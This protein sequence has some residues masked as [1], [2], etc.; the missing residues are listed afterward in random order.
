MSDRPSC[1]RR[2]FLGRAPAAAMLGAVAAAAVACSKDAPHASVTTPAPRRR[3]V[4]ENSRQGDRH[5][6]ITRPGA[7]DAIMGYAGQASVL[8]GE[9]V[10]LYV[11]TTSRAF[12]VIAFRRGWY[13]GDLARRV[14][15]SGKVRGHRQRKPTMLRATNTVQ[16]D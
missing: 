10:T 7:Q 12:R 2:E 4:A 14:W 1:T 11:S 5:W 16:A 15:E 8:A 3:A 6:E 13:G 9:P